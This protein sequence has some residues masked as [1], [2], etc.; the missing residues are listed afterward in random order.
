MVLT[1]ANAPENATIPHDKSNTTL[2]RIAV[3]RLESTSRTPTFMRIAVA[4]AKIAD[5]IAKSNHILTVND[6]AVFV[7]VWI[8]T[9]FVL[10]HRS[11]T[12]THT[13]KS[14]VVKQV[15]HGNFFG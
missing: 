1:C 13:R 2:V 12:H 4:E 8:E 6:I 9:L 10:V 3:A 7:F 14:A 5:N 15:L 11:Q